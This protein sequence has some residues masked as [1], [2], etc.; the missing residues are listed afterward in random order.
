MQFNN[1]TSIHFRH[2]ILRRLNLST[3]GFQNTS[4]KVQRPSIRKWKI[5]VSEGKSH[6]VHLRPRQDWRHV[7]FLSSPLWL[8]RNA[9]AFWHF[10]KPHPT[11]FWFN[12]YQI[13][14]LQKRPYWNRQVHRIPY[15]RPLT[16]IVKFSDTGKL[17]LKTT[18][19][20]K[21]RYTQML[22]FF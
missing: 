13:D 19:N 9:E 12:S 17:E 8:Q 11:A 20:V 6:H 10:P 4:K 15:T 7:H 2:T 1:W 22:C 18:F 5:Y 16:S 3:D 21:Q 14:W